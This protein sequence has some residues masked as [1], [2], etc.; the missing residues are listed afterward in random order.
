M[1]FSETEIKN[2]KW[3]NELN[4]I[5]K[6]PDAENSE[7]LFLCCF[8]RDQLK[9]SEQ[10]TIDFILFYAQWTKNF[11]REGTTRH[12]NMVYERKASGVLI[13][14]FSSSCS[15]VKVVSE[16]TGH[17]GNTAGGNIF[18][19]ETS[20]CVAEKHD[21]KDFF[22][23][24]VFH[25]SPNDRQENWNN[26]RIPEEQEENEEKP[27]EETKVFGKINDGNRFYRVVEKTGKW[28]PF[29]SLDSGLLIDAETE[30]GEMVKAYSRADKF[31]SLPKEPDTMKALIELLSKTLPDEGEHKGKKK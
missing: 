21:V 15:Q 7:R 2:L 16:T 28:G 25:V 11:S 8:C 18:K 24:S 1:T 4:R 22:A 5:L 26:L 31:F 17:M 9:W 3:R 30:K 27:M 12:V 20:D 14:K 10:K 23:P 6:K 29:L 13:S 19:S